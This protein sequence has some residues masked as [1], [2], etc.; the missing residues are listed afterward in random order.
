MYNFIDVN[1]VS[2]GVVLPSE[3]L[4]INGDFI[5][6][7]IAGYRTLTVQGRE[8]LSPDVVGYTT[9][10]RDGSRIKSKRFPERIITIT[11]QLIAESNEAFRE[12]Y[13]KL[14]AIL[15]VKDAELIFNDEQDKFFVGTPCVIDTVNPGTNSV[16]GK[17]E[18]LCADPFKYSVA[19]YEAESNL[20]ENGFLID[21]K[22]TY[23]AFPTLEAEFLKENESDAALTGS[24][25]CGYVAFFNDEEKI[26]QLG[27]PAEADTATYPKSQTLVAQQF[28][29]EAAWGSVAQ[30]NWATNSSPL[31][32]SREQHQ[33]GNVKMAVCGYRSAYEPELS[34]TLL[35]VT[36]T[37][38]KPRVAYKVTA[39][40]FGREE[41]RINVRVTIETTMPDAKRVTSYKNKVASGAQITLKP[42][43][44]GYVSSTIGA[45]FGA[46]AGTY[47]LWDSSVKNGRVR[48]TNQK[49]LVGVS[50]QVT[51]WVRLSDTGLSA[52]GTKV[53]STTGVITS[54]YGLKAGIQIGSSG[55]KYATLKEESGSWM[56]NGT[57]IKTLDVTVKDL[58]A[59]TTEIE[60]IK[61]K[62]ERTD[63]I[64]DKVGIIEETD[65]ANLEINTY[66]APVANEW[67]LAPESFGTEEEWHGPTITRTIPADA[68][69]DVG[70]ANFTFSYKHKIGVGSKSYSTTSEYGEFRAILVSGTGDARKAL[71]TIIVNKEDGSK[72]AD[73]FFEVNSK[74]VA[75]FALDLSHNKATAKTCTITKSGATVTFNAYGKTDSYTDAS[76]K[77]VAVTEITF[78]FGQFYNQPTL[79]YNGIYLAKFVK[80]N[81]NTWADIP[82]KFSTNDVL[83]VD[84]KNG[85]IL[86]NGTPTPSLG[87][88][89][90]D[91][92]EFYL[93]PG[94]NQIGYAY[95]HWVQPEAAP[96]CRVRY[97]EV[98]I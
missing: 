4:M 6:N 24:G 21:Y 61:F 29:N 47:Y 60:D 98:F 55:W 86:L 76:I 53:T 56:V 3:A 85:E 27:D 74:R 66:E 89:G 97:R 48:I 8:A 23:P 82:N 2:D 83:T 17:F 12:A 7:Q 31:I 34:G 92:E 9:G 79:Y 15:N 5:E 95:S 18:I 42:G 54:G 1:E 20:V 41:D 84:C 38:A 57:Y 43:T 16:I 36:N 14:A 63:K 67:Y 22:G 73:V 39:K 10:V 46:V 88:L 91:W 81:S 52:S 68:T 45:S 87:A 50:G 96:K 62:V 19:E 32:G 25:D 58:A 65:C 13:N 80:N 44:Q 71:A 59:D 51:C 75:S 78:F 49:S 64:D 40:A 30:S 28:D 72:D 69:G 33:M 90:N 70:A 35:S 11:Y 26:I 94:L 37:T 77:D 93:T